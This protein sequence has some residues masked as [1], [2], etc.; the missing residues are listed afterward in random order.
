[1]LTYTVLTGSMHIAQSSLFELYCGT[2]IALHRFPLDV[3]QRRLS[4]Y[5]E[6]AELIDSTTKIN[7]RLI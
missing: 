4:K 5:P 2:L 1:M 3:D 7:L 6:Q